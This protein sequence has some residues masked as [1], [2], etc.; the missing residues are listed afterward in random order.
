[1]P[2]PNAAYGRINAMY[3]K[4]TSTPSDGNVRIASDSIFALPVLCFNNQY[5]EFY[6]NATNVMLGFASLCE[7][8]L[9]S[10]DRHLNQSPA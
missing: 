7:P 6:Y 2:G 1:M 5:S 9:I 8:S 10:K 3:C 4:H